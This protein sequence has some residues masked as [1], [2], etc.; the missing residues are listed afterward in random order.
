MIIRSKEK[1]Y[2]DIENSDIS[3]PRIK[4]VFPQLLSN[5]IVPVT[6]ISEPQ[7]IQFALRYLYDNDNDKDI[8]LNLYNEDKK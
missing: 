4:R 3:I 6:P 7:G 8:H 2:K 1:F 5:V